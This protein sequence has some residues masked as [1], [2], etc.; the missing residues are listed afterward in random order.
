MWA[1]EEPKIAN[2]SIKQ[3][4]SD[5][6]GQRQQPNHSKRV[7]ESRKQFSQCW[8]QSPQSRGAFWLFICLSGMAVLWAGFPEENP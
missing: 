4:F 2:L 3:S 6:F 5:E 1:L 8:Q 7:G